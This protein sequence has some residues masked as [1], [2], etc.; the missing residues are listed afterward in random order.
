MLR[1]QA[2]LEQRSS[3]LR[4]AN[5]SEQVRAIL[6]PQLQERTDMLANRVNVVNVNLSETYILLLNNMDRNISIMEERVSNLESLLGV[7]LI[8][9]HEKLLE[10]RGE[11]VEAREEVMLQMEKIYDVSVDSVGNLGTALRE[12]MASMMGDHEELR[13]SFIVPVRRTIQEAQTIFRGVME[14]YKSERR[15]G[16]L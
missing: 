14:T 1:A 16:I 5:I 15:E 7:D 13:N 2:L 4:G 12:A 11:L 6:D 10:A 8:N 9:V 3:E